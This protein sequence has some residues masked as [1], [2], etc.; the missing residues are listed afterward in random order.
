MNRNLRT[1]FTVCGL[2]IGMTTLSVWNAEGKTISKGSIKTFTGTVSSISMAD[3]EKETKSEIIVTDAKGVKKG[4]LVT[5][6]TT[7]YGIKSAPLTLEKIRRDDKVRVKYRTTKEG[8][9]EAISVRI[10]H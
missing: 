5:A 3:K 8:I 4:F 9:D 7:L 1:I 2:L 6:T 10:E